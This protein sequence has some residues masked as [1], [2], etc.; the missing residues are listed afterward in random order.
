MID[1]HCHSIFSDGEFT[2]SELLSKAQELNLNYFAITDHNN[3]FAY[4]NIDSSHFNGKL[5]KGV[6]IVTSFEGHIIEI[7]GYG[8]DIH[9]INDWSRQ[10]EENEY[11]YA[12]KIC[13]RLY[14]IFEE[15]NI[16]YTKEKDIKEKIPQE[17]PTGWIKLN[18]Y[19]D[20]LKYTMNEKIIGAEI[21]VSYANFNKKGLNNPYSL[22][23]LNEGTRFPT[24]REVV[25]LIH[26]SKG[27]CFL[28]HLYQYNVGNHI[29][30][31]NR[32][33]KEVRL[34]GIETYHSSFTRQQILEIN[35]Y[36]DNHNLYKSG[37]SDY[38]GKLKPGI[39]L[40]LDLQ[41]KDD[42]ITPWID[43]IIG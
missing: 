31:L 6:E 9:E 21:L 1:L 29:E 37:G 41:I 8:I 19:Q 27:L 25:E 40:G 11:E 14:D 22:L 24:L 36:A 38:H 39:K 43:K 15:R 34:D 26:R 3:C 13:D 10:N 30:F 20:L 42:L 2:P 16:S 33:L 7:L 17:D 35:Q 4:E 18:I 12:K 5:I 28:A 32:I 23:F